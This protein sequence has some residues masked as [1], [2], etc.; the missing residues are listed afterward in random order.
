MID[1]YCISQQH[2][3]D[4]DVA[5][6]AASF[7]NSTDQHIFLTGR[8]GTG[9]T[10][11]LKHIVKD[12]HKNAVVAAPTGIAAI[13]AGGVTLHSLFQ[14]PLGIFVPSNLNIDHGELDVEINTPS[15]L[16]KHLRLSKPKRRMLQLMEL[17]I[18]DEV[19]MLRADMADAID[20]VLR[21]IRRRRNVPFG[22]VQLLLIGD[23]QQ[24]PPV[25]KHREWD[26]LSPYY[27]SMYFF[28]AMVFADNQPVFIELEKIYRQHDV[29][30]IALLNKVRDKQLDAVDIAALNKRYYPELT[31]EQKKGAVY[32]TTHNRKADELNTKKLEQ[33]PGKVWRYDA[34]VDGDFPER[35]YPVEEQLKLKKGAQIMFIKNDYSGEQRYFNGKIGHI[36][37]LSREEIMVEFP[38]GSEPVVI[39]PYTWE[40]KRYTLDKSSQEIEEKIIGSFVQYPIR[41]AWAITIH[42]SQGLTF[43]KA[44]IDLSQAF[45][46]GQAY[47][48]LSRLTSMEGLMLAKPMPD[49]SLKVDKALS[50]FVSQTSEITELKS[51]LKDKAFDYTQRFL[52]QV[53]DF[54]NIYYQLNEHLKTYNKDEA[55]SEKQKHKSLVQTALKSVNEMQ[56]TAIRFQNQIKKLMYDRDK[57]KLVYLKKRVEAAKQYFEPKLQE[58][59]QQYN[60]KQKELEHTKGAKQFRNELEDIEGLFFGKVKS[61][62]KAML[63]LDALIDGIEPDVKKIKVNQNRLQTE[64][65]MSKIKKEQTKKPD[66]EDKKNQ[67][68]SSEISLQ[69]YKEGKKP[70]EIAAER[71]LVLSTIEGHLSQCVSKGLIPAT[72]FVSE[73]C[74][75][76]VAKAYHYIGSPKLSD[77]HKH[78]DNKYSYSDL[79]FALSGYFAG[80]KNE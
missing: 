50:D 61:M 25:L 53:F 71:G 59:I 60:K 47:V 11:F 76:E 28:D 19:S 69:M 39:E 12:T 78:M 49:Y 14:L 42:K 10:T 33:L 27:K 43:E 51:I 35:N 70:E 2:N 44:I 72:D 62:V 9:K 4:T 54:G 66:K 7:V 65:N 30:F 34:E 58:H 8:A 15:T 20:M 74:M 13:N 32:L 80:L 55:R 52:L 67:S 46:P 77:L 17:L 63:L 68:P 24:L 18:I 45:A 64:Y 26:Y 29:S 3:E 48:A 31:E 75:E 37:S 56:A 1:S 40:N 21:T 79:R 73:T 5:A 38:D 57:D 41:L 6:I 23:M 36:A 16:M 22:G